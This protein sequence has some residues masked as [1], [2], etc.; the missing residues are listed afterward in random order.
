MIKAVRFVGW[1]VGWLVGWFGEILLERLN[2]LRVCG[3]HQGIRKCKVE[4]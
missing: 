4:E 3:M 2:S 1:L